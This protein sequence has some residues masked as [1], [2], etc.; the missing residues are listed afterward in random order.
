MT[1]QNTAVL[2][3]ARSF[4]LIKGKEYSRWQLSEA[5]SRTGQLL[6]RKLECTD[7]FGSDVPM[8]AEEV[9]RLRTTGDPEK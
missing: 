9:E 3:P 6:S 5:R 1:Q 4:V 2:V 8:S 7:A